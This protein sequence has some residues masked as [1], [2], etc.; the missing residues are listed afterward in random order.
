MS[1]SVGFLSD[2][3]SVTVQDLCVKFRQ[4][5]PPGF[6]VLVFGLHQSRLPIGYRKSKVACWKFPAVVE[7]W[8][9][10]RK[11]PAIFS[12]QQVSLSLS[13]SLRELGRL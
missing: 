2:L 11:V 5:P 9:E 1:S 6:R 3:R 10:I 4:Q 7:V 13:E 8:R 12:P